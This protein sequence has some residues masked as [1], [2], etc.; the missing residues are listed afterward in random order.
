MTMSAEELK[1]TDSEWCE[2]FNRI[3][4][5]SMKIYR[6]SQTAKNTKRNRRLMSSSYSAHR[7][8]RAEWYAYWQ[9]KL[10]IKFNESVQQKLAD[11]RWELNAIP[12]QRAA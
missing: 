10:G 1:Q 12:A 11:L 3:E 2:Q 8:S 7:K 5:I 9:R 4:A 6:R